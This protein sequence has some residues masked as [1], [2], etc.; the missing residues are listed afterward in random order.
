M[1]DSFEDL[2]LVPSTIPVPLSKLK[3]HVSFA[4]NIPGL[5][6]TMCKEYDIHEPPKNC[7][8]TSFM[9]E[10]YSGSHDNGFGIE[11]MPAYE[12][13]VGSENSWENEM[14]Y[15][16]TMGAEMEVNISSDLMLSTDEC[17]RHSS[18]HGSRLDESDFTQP[19]KIYDSNFSD[20]YVIPPTSPLGPLTRARSEPHPFSVR[21]GERDV[22]DGITV[23]LG[24]HSL[25]MLT[26]PKD[27]MEAPVTICVVRYDPR[28]RELTGTIAVR[29]FSFE[30]RVFVKHTWNSWET[31]TETNARYVWSRGSIHE[32]MSSVGVDMFAFTVPVSVDDLS[33]K[34]RELEFIAGHTYSNKGQKTTVWDN[35]GGENYRAVTVNLIDTNLPNFIQ[36]EI[37]AHHSPHRSNGIPASIEAR[38]KRVKVP[39]HSKSRVQPRVQSSTQPES[40]QSSTQPES[41]PQPHTHPQRQ[42]QPQRQRQRQPQLQLQPQPQPQLQPQ[43]ETHSVTK[44]FSP[45]TTKM[46]EKKSLGLKIITN[47][48][49]PS[50][51]RK[52][53]SIP[54]YIPPMMD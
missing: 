4:D 11:D 15:I 28:A 13:M 53:S 9:S 12:N 24:D 41:E 30:K 37:S 35:N 20:E 50:P 18:P 21:E 38:Q 8:R 7:S 43:P 16:N 42:P 33:E 51:V 39:A 47:G 44:S 48:S 52:V 17:R 1:N 31:V 36:S 19:A 2:A 6:L 27:D 14:K 3:G 23:S 32:S 29:N 10:N 25:K 54:S 5:S 49:G 46:S 40:E 34:G 26:K 22:F 45:I